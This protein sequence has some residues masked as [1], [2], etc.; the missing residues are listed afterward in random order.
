ML[1]D[2]TDII[3]SIP[4]IGRPLKFP[5]DVVLL[6]IPIPVGDATQATVSYIRQIGRYARFA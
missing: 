4:A 2:G 6:E 5:M 3:R 1:I